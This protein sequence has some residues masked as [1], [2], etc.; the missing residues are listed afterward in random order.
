MELLRR[1]LLWASTNPWLSTR[2]PRRRF[3]RRAVRRFMPGEGLEHALAEAVDLQKLGVPTLLT[4]LGENVE[5][6]E[7]T[8]GN[9]SDYAEILRETEKANLDIEVSIKPTHLGLDVDPGL[10]LRSVRELAARAEGRGT[11]WIDMEGSPYVDPTLT[12]YRD[13]RE[14][15]ENVGLCLQAYLHRTAEDLESLIE[16]GGPRIRLVKGAYAEPPEIAFPE[17]RDVDASYLALSRR[18]IDHLGSG[19]DGFLGLGT[20]DPAMIRP[21]TEDARAAGL[22]ERAFEIEM[23]YGIGLREQRRLIE[24]G[25][26]LRVL[27]SYGEAWFPW[28]MRRLAER[29]GNVWFVVKSLFR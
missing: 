17:K 5:T 6:E 29:P 9:V 2:L 18:L 11:V 13:L 21:L 3:V 26:P 12:L 24:G 19:G 4:I 28:Y 10:A 25:V 16:L 7:E 8:R 20:H 27:I 22:D 23:L 1:C 14:T 15:H